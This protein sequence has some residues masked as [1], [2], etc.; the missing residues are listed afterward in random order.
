MPVDMPETAANALPTD[1]EEPLTVT[2]MADGTILIQTTETP[3]DDLVPR[4]RAIAEERTSDRIFL[5]AD[6]AIDW[7]SMAVVMGALNAAGFDN[8]GLVTDIGGPT[9]DASDG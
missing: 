9:L 2:L 8:I 1:P 3:R 4:L 5:R 6:G 7:S